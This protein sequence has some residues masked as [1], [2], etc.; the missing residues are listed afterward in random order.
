MIQS[1]VSFFFP[2]RWSVVTFLLSV[3]SDCISAFGGQWLHFS[4]R[5]TVIAFQI[6]AFGG[7][8]A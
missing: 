2:F 5:W 1:F 7:R 8:F 4:F 6:S 3:D